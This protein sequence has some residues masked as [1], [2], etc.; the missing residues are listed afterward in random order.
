MHLI[1]LAVGIRDPEHLAAVQ[2]TRRIVR[3]DID[4][5]RPVVL[6][7][8]R[9]RPK[10][11]E[12]IITDG[13]IYWVIKGAVRCRQRVHGLEAAVDDEGKACCLMLLDPMLVTT[14]PIP[15]KPFQGWRYLDPAKAPPDLA[16][17]TDGDA[18]PPE[19]AAELRALGLL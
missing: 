2:R 10:Q 4:G 14:V 3:S 1:K 19:M 17:A 16:A 11:P 15:H 12:A 9:R 6:G 18:M 7:S 8:T 5:G 13:S